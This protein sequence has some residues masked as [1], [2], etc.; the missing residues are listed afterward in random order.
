MARSETSERDTP[1]ATPRE[2]AGESQSPTD[3]QRVVPP[4]PG[5]AT[6][7]MAG[8]PPPPTRRNMRLARRRLVREQIV[9][10]CV[11]VAMLAATVLLLCFEWL[12]NGTVG[13]N[14]PLFVHYLGGSS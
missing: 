3:R 11:L 14:A 1:V 2:R 7:P 12:A 10:V 5:P 8:S 6:R 9:V 4:D 13:S